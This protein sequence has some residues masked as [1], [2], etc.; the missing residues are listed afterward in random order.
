MLDDDIIARL[1]AQVDVLEHR[2]QGALQLT[3][4]IRQKA[5]PNYTPAAY[6]TPNGLAFGSAQ[7]GTGYFVQG[8]EEVISIVL[9]IR[10]AA[11]V[12]G[13]KGQ[14][15]LAPLIWAVVEAL[16]G[17]APHV[18]QEPED[19]PDQDEVAEIGVLVPRRGSL[20]RLDAGTIF[21]QLDF[22]IQQQLRITS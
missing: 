8:V 15:A 18:D 1:E 20:V 13:A 17:W 14:K 6:V 7:F 22:A 9:V 2:V 5:L 21:Y 16:A 12:R 19:A 3:E 4:M 10:T 11:D